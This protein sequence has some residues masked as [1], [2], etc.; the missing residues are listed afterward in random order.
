MY[1]VV[2][3]LYLSSW[4]FTD[5]V[6]SV[7]FHQIWETCSHFFF[8]NVLFPT[9]FSVSSLSGT[10]LHTRQFDTVLQSAFRL[11]LL[12]WVCT[13]TDPLPPAR[14]H[15][16]STS[17]AGRPTTTTSSP[18]LPSQ[19]QLFPDAPVKPWALTSCLLGG[20]QLEYQRLRWGWGITPKCRLPPS[21]LRGLI[22]LI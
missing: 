18:S 4:V 9:S 12:W 2:Y 17:D 13:F 8:F 7:G 14:P 21:Q 6:G 11:R 15:A 3:S 16:S 20:T 5:L 1:L 19:C 22:T 10:Q